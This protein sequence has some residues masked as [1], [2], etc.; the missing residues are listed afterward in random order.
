MGAGGM[1]ERGM[2]RVIIGLILLTAVASVGAAECR[3]NN[4]TIDGKL[5]ACSTCCEATGH[6]WT[7][8]TTQQPQSGTSTCRDPFPLHQEGAGS[9]FGW[10][11]I[12]SVRELREQN[13]A[14]TAANFAYRNGA[15]MEEIL[16]LY[17]PN[18][19]I[20]DPAPLKQA[21]KGRP[22]TCVAR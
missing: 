3:V 22:N 2:K 8:C 1:N 10:F 18:L 13:A 19:G 17:G 5:T 6:C 20:G 16:D 21:V 4:V 11:D 15:T 14:R 7:D 12:P 9:A